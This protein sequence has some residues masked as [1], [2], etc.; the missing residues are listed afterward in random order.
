MC[1]N[2]YILCMK[3][4]QILSHPESYQSPITLFIS[5]DMNQ[6]KNTGAVKKK[7]ERK[8]SDFC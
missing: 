6:R 7:K 5:S 3:V 2:R 1:I 4:V 8:L